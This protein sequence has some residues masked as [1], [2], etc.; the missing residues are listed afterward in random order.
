MTLNYMKTE[1]LVE[2]LLHTL[3]KDICDNYR[4]TNL[5]GEQGTGQKRKVTLLDD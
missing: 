5:C 3:T 2:A 1:T 4:H